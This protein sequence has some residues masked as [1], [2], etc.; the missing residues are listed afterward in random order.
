MIIGQPLLSLSLLMLLKVAVN[1]FLWP[2]LD[3]FFH[4]QE[5][6][7]QR[8][9]LQSMWRFSYERAYRMAAVE[10]CVCASV[11]SG[12]RLQDEGV[13]GTMDAHSDIYSYK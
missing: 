8:S 9:M 6:T 5:I 1:P 12:S 7:P 3:V 4:G 2:A 13:P 11:P 10:K